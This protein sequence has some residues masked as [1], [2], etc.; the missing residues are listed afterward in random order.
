MYGIPAGGRQGEKRDRPLG[1]AGTIA[2]L[3]RLGAKSQV[4]FLEV[5]PEAQT[6]TLFLPPPKGSLWDKAAS[7]KEKG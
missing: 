1:E 2:V 4:F 7:L 5:A 3:K 6:K